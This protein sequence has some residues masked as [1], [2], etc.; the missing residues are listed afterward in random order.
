MPGHLGKT[1]ISR[2]GASIHC[3]RMTPLVVSGA[4]AWAP[5]SGIR[6]IHEH[7]SSGT[8]IA[9]KIIEAPMPSKQ[10][11][12]HLLTRLSKHPCRAYW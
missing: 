3:N 6:C 9:D 8:G 4:L 10:S 5:V 11:C 1:T 2:P 7:V 12:E